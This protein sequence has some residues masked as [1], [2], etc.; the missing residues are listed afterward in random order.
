MFCTMGSVTDKTVCICLT[1]NMR[2]MT[3]K[4]TGADT[5]FVCMTSGAA[6][7]GVVLTRIGLHFLSFRIVMANLTGNNALTGFILD[8]LFYPG[9][10]NI[11]R[12]VRV[13]MAL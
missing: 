12:C 7:I 1:G 13:L 3:I 11:K 9:K 8:L 4:T 5:M 2:L 6:D 10:R